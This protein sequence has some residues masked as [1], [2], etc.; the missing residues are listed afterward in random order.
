MRIHKKKT[1]FFSWHF[2]T[3]L[4]VFYS[5]LIQAGQDARAILQEALDNQAT[6]H[7][8]MLCS[9]GSGR[10]ALRTWISQMRLPN[11]EIVRLE[12]VVVPDDLAKTPWVQRTKVYYTREGVTHCLWDKLG[13]ERSVRYQGGIPHERLPSSNVVFITSDKHFQNG[14]E[15]WL[16]REKLPNQ[17]VKEY[18]IDKE[19][20]MIL[21]LTTFRPN[22]MILDKLAYTDIDLHPVFPKKHFSLPTGLKPILVND[23]VAA[24]DLI[25]GKLFDEHEK[26][27]LER[28]D[29]RRK[30][31]RKR[32]RRWRRFW[33]LVGVSWD[34]FVDNA[35][36]ILMLMSVS[37]LTGALVVKIRHNR[38]KA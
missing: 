15:C 2:W 29:R 14:R 20:N 28:A 30:Q 1:A 4:V 9:F 31:V 18:V 34:R 5:C 7:Y 22:G 36:W 19:W 35:A 11:G 23:K 37:C 27:L 21:V 17:C 38:E 32:S 13:W 25:F 16:I 33:W 24:L 26:A 12:E 8:K 10:M 3:I 6:K